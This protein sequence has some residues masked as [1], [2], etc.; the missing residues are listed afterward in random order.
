MNE[1]QRDELLIRLDE[2]TASSKRWEEKHDL[3]HKDEKATRWR[4]VA[5]LYAAVIAGL[6]KIIFWN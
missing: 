1:Q 3:Q 5:P 6:S 4:T 2:R